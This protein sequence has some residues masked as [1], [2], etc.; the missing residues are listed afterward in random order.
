MC[1]LITLMFYTDSN[2]RLH[3]LMIKH[4]LVRGDILSK[5]DINSNMP[6]KNSFFKSAFSVDNVIFGLED[7]KLK[8]LLIRRKG[9]PYKGE[10]ALA[11][12]S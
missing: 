4:F 2:F 1:K 5:E 7:S 6:F 9:E 8:V 12:R 11:R 3:H 10:W